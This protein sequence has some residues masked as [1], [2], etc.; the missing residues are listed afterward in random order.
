MLIFEQIG[1][2]MV[3]QLVKGLNFDGICDVIL[4]QP[5][6]HFPRAICTLLINQ[7]LQYTLPAMGNLWYT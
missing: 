3:A 7:D 5:A 6:H 4:R 2:E 1:L